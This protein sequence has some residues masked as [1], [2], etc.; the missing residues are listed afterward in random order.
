LGVTAEPPCPQGG[1][2]R[3][4]GAGSMSGRLRFALDRPRPDQDRALAVIG[5]HQCRVERMIE[6]GVVDAD[7]EEF[8]PGLILLSQ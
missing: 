4:A 2:G 8:P 6:C 1:T 3:V 7:G 5:R